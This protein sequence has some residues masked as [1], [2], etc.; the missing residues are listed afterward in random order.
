MGSEMGIRESIDKCEFAFKDIFFQA[1]VGIRDSVASRVLGDV[2]NSQRTFPA[3]LNLMALLV[4]F[5]A[6]I[7]LVVLIRQNLDGQLLH[8][9]LTVTIQAHYLFRVIG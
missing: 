3:C 2:Y 5:G 1:E 7:F 9:L 6:Q 4:A 8:N